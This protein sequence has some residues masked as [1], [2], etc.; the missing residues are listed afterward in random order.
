ME[1]E[2]TLEELAA[3]AQSRETANLLPLVNIMGE[4]PSIKSIQEMSLQLVE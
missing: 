1:A 4:L 2:T 3:Q